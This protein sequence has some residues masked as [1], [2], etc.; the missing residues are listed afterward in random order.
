MGM[1]CTGTRQLHGDDVHMDVPAT[2]GLNL[3]VA[4]LTAGFSVLF[5]TGIITLPVRFK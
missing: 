2:R 4:D 5:K 1:T 3:T